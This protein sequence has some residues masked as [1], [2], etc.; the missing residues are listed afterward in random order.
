MSDVL[1][2]I[3]TLQEAIQY[4]ADPDNCLQYVAQKRWGNSP[5]CPHC[6]SDRVGFITTRR[7]WKCKHRDCRK[8]FSVKVGTIMEDSPLGLDKWLAAIWLI[9][10][11]KNGI[12]SCEIARSLGITQKT[13]WFLLHRIRLA[14]QTGT[15]E[16]LS[17]EVEAD[18]T[19]VGG[20]AEN[21]H[22]AKRK[23]KIRGRGTSGKAIVLGLIERG[24]NVVAKVIPDTSRET[25]HREVK[26]AVSPVT[27]G[28]VKD[29]ITHLYTDGHSGYQ[30]L[31]EQYIHRIVDHA[32]EYVRGN[33][34]TNRIENFWTLLKRSLKGTYV[35]VEPEHL[36]RY[37]EEQVFRFNNRKAKDGERFNK[38][39]EGIQGRRIT[40]RKLIRKA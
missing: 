27:E 8:Q 14:M 7:V 5:I 29:Y 9:V 36:F 2:S 10:N 1:Q 22:E 19:Y 37:V 30:G 31:D 6:G 24:G 38:A 32:I 33:V 26:E 23:Q 39:L 15:F 17:G 34:S 35:A 21:M 3:K 12:S 16:K 40:Y 20:K 4:F 13:A 25:L 11:A 18:E 28:S